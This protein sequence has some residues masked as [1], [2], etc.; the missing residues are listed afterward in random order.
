MDMKKFAPLIGFLIPWLAFGSTITTSNM[1]LILPVPGSESGPTWAQLLNTAFTSIDSHNHT[2]GSGARVPTAGLNINA[3]LPMG[4]YN[5]SLPRATLYTNQAGTL[6]T[7]ADK[8]SVYVVN[9]DLYYNNSAGTAVQVT[10]G[11]AVNVAG[12]GNISGMGSTTAAVTYSNITKNFTFTQSS[13]VTADLSVGKVNVYEDVASSNPITIQSPAGVGSA[14]SI[15]LPAAV[16]ASTKILTMTSAGVVGDAYDVD[17][18]TIEVSSNSI[19]VKDAGVTQAKLA[20][21]ATG[22]TVGAG[23]VA[24]SSSSSTFSTTAST[25]DNVTNLNITITTTGRPVIIK[26]IPDGG[27]TEATCGPVG[28]S[29]SWQLNNVTTGSFWLGLDTGSSVFSPGRIQTIDFPTAGTYNYKLLVKANS[30][31]SY[32]CQYTKLIAYEL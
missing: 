7:T 15:T 29:G 19:R 11:G 3:D 8:N 5:L 9:G 4:N 22:T 24:V 21:R 13:G 17:N 2:P 18:S 10:S 1:G 26:A 12:S 6:S 27:N 25:Y 16:P 32:L 31:N 30:S 14:Y 28:G 20:S 23:G